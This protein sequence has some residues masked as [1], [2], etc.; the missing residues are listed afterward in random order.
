MASTR[1]QLPMPNITKPPSSP[2][3]IE[4][5]DW[6]PTELAVCRKHGLTYTIRSSKYPHTIKSPTRLLLTLNETQTF[7]LHPTLLRT[8]AP[9]LT[10]HLTPHTSTLQIST[11]PPLNNPRAW[12]IFFTWLYSLDKIPLFDYTPVRSSTWRTKHFRD[13]I[14]L[15]TW[16]RAEKFEKYL[17]RIV[18]HELW[19]STGFTPSD[20]GVVADGVNRLVAQ[21]GVKKPALFIY[22]VT[23]AYQTMMQYVKLI[24]FDTSVSQ[25]E[26]SRKGWKFIFPEWNSAIDNRPE[27][28]TSFV[29][30]HQT[31]RHQNRN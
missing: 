15:A 30:L 29:L 3:P 13:A 28:G 6:D 18:M 4:Y 27:S 26:I 11:A 12:S 31:S 23:T 2:P 9:T 19:F 7:S 5:L 8:F 20:L 24:V 16:L 1:F 21:T 10:T 22:I 25:L 17:L 14:L